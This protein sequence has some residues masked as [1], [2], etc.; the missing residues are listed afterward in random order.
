MTHRQKISLWMWA[1]VAIMIL[2]SMIARG[3][4]YPVTQV[5]GDGYKKTI[6]ARG[7]IKITD[8]EVTV[9]T[10]FERQS[11]PVMRTFKVKGVTYHEIALM[12]CRMLVY[13]HAGRMESNGVMYE[14]GYVN[15]YKRFQRK[16]EELTR[17]T[18][19]RKL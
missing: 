5:S 8:E 16:P 18:F 10:S 6:T 13:V 17:Y 19:K 7:V 12:S 2:L 1:T 4:E 11:L 15:I 3:Q 14:V 9:I